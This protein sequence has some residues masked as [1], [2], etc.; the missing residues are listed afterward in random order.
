[1][2]PDGICLDPWKLCEYKLT[3]MSSNRDPQDNWR[4]MTQI[5]GYLYGVSVFF[6][7]LTTECDLHVLYVERGL[8]QQRSGVLV[9]RA[10]VLPARRSRKPGTCCTITPRERGGYKVT[11]PSKLAGT[12]FKEADTE[13]KLRILVGVEALEKEGKT[14]FALTAPGPLAVFDFDTGMEGV[15]HKFA[16]KKK[17]YV[18]DYRRLG[19]VM[20]N[21]PENWVLLWEKFKR[22]YIAAMDAPVDTHRR[23]RHRHGGVGA[24]A[25]GEVRS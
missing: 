24:A 14:H 17:I 6:D 19:N 3:W 20:T 10:A 7:R 23:A 21:T 22:E 13:V 5:K 16:G 12:G 9:L 11:I 1:M 4:W 18:S 8:P 15:V 2:S 25:Y